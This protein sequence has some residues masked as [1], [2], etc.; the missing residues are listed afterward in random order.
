MEE[1]NKKFR[2]IQYLRGVL[3]WGRKECIQYMYQADMHMPVPLT[4]AVVI[5]I[6]VLL[7]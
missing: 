6:L 5:I 1:L 2:R 7:I 3:V 4:V